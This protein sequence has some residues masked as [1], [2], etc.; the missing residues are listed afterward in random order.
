MG[1]LKTHT[2]NVIGMFT[3]KT[4]GHAFGFCEN[5]EPNSWTHAFDLPHLVEVGDH[6]GWPYRYA[7]VLKTVAYVVVDED[8]HGRPVVEK[9]DIRKHRIFGPNDKWYV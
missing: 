6:I 4:H 3:E 5:D 8:E 9:W 1:Y 2:K 7:K